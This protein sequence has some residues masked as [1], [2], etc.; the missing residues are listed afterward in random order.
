MKSF[1]GLLVL[2]FLFMN[3]E[4]P[5]ETFSSGPRL[6]WQIVN[7]VVMGGRS[8]SQMQVTDAGYGQFSGSVSL[9][10]NGGFA[11]CRASVEQVNLDSTA[12][13]KIR[14]R[15]DGQ[16]YDFRVRISGPYSRASYRKSFTTVEGQWQ[17][18]ELP[19]RQFEPTFR[20]RLLSDVPPIEPSAIREI[21]FLIANKQKGAFQLDIE[22]ISAY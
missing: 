12:G 7:D 18:V 10:N 16:E 1:F 3:T 22:D 4:I 6:D 14:V 15:G 20:G 5:L 17:T 2:A 19:W 9:E 11:S 13:V 21:G 8:S